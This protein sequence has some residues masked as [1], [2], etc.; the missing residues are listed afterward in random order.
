MTLDVEE[1]LQRRCVVADTVEAHSHVNLRFYAW[2]LWVCVERNGCFRFKPE[3]VEKDHFSVFSESSGINVWT[4]SGSSIWSSFEFTRLTTVGWSWSSA[5][6][7]SSQS[8]G[9]SHISSLKFGLTVPESVSQGLDLGS[10]PLSAPRPGSIW[11][12]TVLP[13]SPDTL[14]KMMFESPLAFEVLEVTLCFREPGR[15]VGGW[16]RDLEK[17][18][19]GQERTKS[20]LFITWWWDLPEQEPG[21]CQAL[22][23]WNP[24]KQSPYYP[25]PRAAPG[26]PP[27]SPGAAIQVQD[28]LQGLRH[29]SSPYRWHHSSPYLWWYHVYRQISPYRRRPHGRKA[30]GQGHRTGDR[31]QISQQ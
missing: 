4:T 13:F 5:W 23:G 10:E 31:G 12:S 29:H 17:R 3:N 9:R 20:R 25:S 24:P 6:V 15:Q 2:S 11:S 19:F 7:G 28:Q 14:V 27:Q 26:G 16:T 21:W 18:N 22:Q 30:E 8:V 1:A